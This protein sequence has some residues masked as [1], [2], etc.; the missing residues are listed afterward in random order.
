[1]R[2]GE[3]LLEHS[4]VH[5][6]D[7][8]RA[9]GEQRH[10]NQRL[11]SLLISRGLLDPDHAARALGEQH[12]VAAVLQRHFENRDRS[13]V[14]LLPAALARAWFALP[15]G[16]N[17]D[18]EL[19]VCVRDPRP[20]LAAILAPNGDRIVLAV[21]PASQLERLID[22]A[23]NERVDPSDDF[24]VDM[25]TGSVDVEVD[26]GSGPIVLGVRSD[27]ALADLG[28]MTLV[29]LDD[30]RVDKDPTQS[31]SLAVAGMR[32]T[33]IPPFAALTIDGTIAAIDAAG[34]RDAATDLAM[35]F[36]HARWAATLLLTIK[37]G[38]ALGHRGHGT[39]LSN[40]AVQAIALPLGA[41]SIIKLAHDS[42]RI[43][44]EPPPGSG[45]IQERLLRLLGQPSAP[46]AAPI[47]IAGRVACVLVVGDSIGG[48]QPAHDLERLAGALADAYAR[49]L[50]DK[51]S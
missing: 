48:G 3:L 36:A 9:L 15:I 34:S 41:P 8:A 11:C 29:E 10:T 7:L 6:P 25:T 47:T 43:A 35:R 14:R 20:E 32:S 40:D 19:I 5:G 16:R 50:R 33:T 31:G 18:G 44:S 12:Q 30:D 42:R 39:L 49:V 26:L 38:A 45:P 27:N 1:M 17:R 4:W 21:G 22:G 24:E 2:I 51:K 28:S 13:L 46:T 23:Y 37:D